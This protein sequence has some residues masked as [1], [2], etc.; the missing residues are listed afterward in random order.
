MASTGNSFSI[1]PALP[2]F[3]FMLADDIGWAD[4]SYNNGT[5]LTPNIDAWAR[6]KGSVMLQDFHS[7]GTVCSPTRATVLTGRHHFRDCVDHVYGCSDMRSCPSLAFEFAPSKTF[8][9]GN[10]VRNAF[11]EDYDS[12]GGAYFAG[13]W[14]LGSFFNDSKAYG[15]LPSSPITH[16]FTK[17]NATI[18]VAPTATTNCQCKAEW[19]DSCDFGHYHKP[20]HCFNG[21]CCFNYWW[22]DPLA[23]HGVT[24]LTWPTPPD[25]SVYLADAFSRYLKERKKQQKPFLAQIS[26][27]NCHIPFIGSKAAKGSCDRGETCRSPGDNEEPFTDQELDYYACLVELDNAVGMILKSLKKYGYYE[28]TM[29]RKMKVVESR[30][31]ILQI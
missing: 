15:G 18:E 19:L 30:N 17:M 14:H 16:G 23:P 7:G 24:N 20:E 21:D 6:A 3:L 5:A 1:T 28:N 26:F 29:V 11:P 12:K 27:H 9:V 8:T 25:D 10:A 22:D 13:K 4:F 2:S 31:L